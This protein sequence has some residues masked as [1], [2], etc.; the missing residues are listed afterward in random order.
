MRWTIHLTYRDGREEV[1]D[2]ENNGPLPEYI[3]TIPRH[4]NAPAGI[5]LHPSPAVFAAPVFTA[6]FRRRLDNRDNW[7]RAFYVEG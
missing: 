3:M 2:F 1:I 5:T 4:L 7:C 6:R